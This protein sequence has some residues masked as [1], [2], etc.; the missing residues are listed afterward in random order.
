VSEELA[1]YLRDIASQLDVDPSS[2]RE[3]LAE[4]QNHLQESMADLEEHGRSRKESVALALERF[5]EARELGRMLNRLHGDPPWV[6][7]GWAILPGLFALA[8]AAGLFSAAWGV[9]IGEAVGRI[10]LLGVCVLVIAAGW[11]KERR[12]AVW[13]YPA[14][15]V[16]LYGVWLWLPWVS[17]DQ[18]RPF[19]Q[20]A[21]PLVMLAVIG[22]YAGYSAYR[23]RGIRIPPLAWALLA[24]M[25]LS[26]VASLVPSVVSDQNPH[27]RTAILAMIPFSLWWMG[28]LLLPVVIGLPFARSQGLPAGLIVVAA[29]YVLVEG[30]LD[31]AYGILIW[32][33]NASAARALACLPGLAFLI[34]P[35]IWV[36]GCRAAKGQTW[37]LVLPALLGLVSASV[38]RGAALQ[39]T[40]I[41]YGADSWL[42]DC[43]AGAQFL[44]LLVLTAVVYR[45]IGPRPAQGAKDMD[46]RSSGSQSL[47]CVANEQRA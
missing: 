26:V 46:C 45:W 19:W 33:S 23:A 12:L 15:G 18:A 3:I 11:A 21:P 22:A 38:V 36:L 6:R 42:R 29:A 17:A 37:G 31:P 47:G 35:P 39:G 41:A 13:S 25:I 8:G 32:T 43:L 27:R 28:L 10:G 24:L 20:V 40:A 4:I 16:L 9:N 14:W 7:V 5:G 1:R 44:L 30:L 2:E 34:V